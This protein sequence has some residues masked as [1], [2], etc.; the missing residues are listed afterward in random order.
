MI[1]PPGEPSAESV[2]GCVALFALFLALIS[3][4]YLMGTVAACLA[5]GSGLLAIWLHYTD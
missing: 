4:P 1:G 2:A 3:A 5:V